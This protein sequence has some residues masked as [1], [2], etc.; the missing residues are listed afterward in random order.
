MDRLLR[1]RCPQML[2]QAMRARRF[3]AAQ[4]RGGRRLAQ[5]WSSTTG[6]F[7]GENRDFMGF[8]QQKMVILLRNSVI[9]VGSH[10]ET[11]DLTNKNWDS[12]RIIADL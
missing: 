2:Q 10:R 9:L 4:G 11:C 12:M 5:R 1:R 8:H 3:Q 7:T 6:I